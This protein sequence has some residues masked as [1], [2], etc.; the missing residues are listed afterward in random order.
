MEQSTEL[1]ANKTGIDMSPVHSKKMIEGSER[2]FTSNGDGKT[3]LNLFEQHYIENADP[4]G[5]VPL[6]GTVKGMMKSAMKTVTGHHPQVFINKLGERL[7]YE[8]SGVRIYEQL[9]NK[10]EYAVDKAMID[11]Q[12]PHDL[13]YGFRG[14]EADPFVLVTG[15]LKTLGADPAAQTPD[16]DA[17]DVA[18]PRL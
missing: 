6:P 12:V 14:Q 3:A 16:A 1:G 4:L 18:S 8:R 9:I 5:S 2:V 13:L 15:C 17:S 10:C 7:A 11:C